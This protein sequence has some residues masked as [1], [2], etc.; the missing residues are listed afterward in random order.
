[1]PRTD[2]HAGRALLGLLLALGTLWLT[3]PGASAQ[4]FPSGP[5]G[6]AIA[7][8]PD[9][10]RKWALLIGIEKYHRANPLR[11]TINDVRCLA[12]TL[13]R[14]GDYDAESVLEIV[15]TNV[16]PR[17]QPLR[18]SLMAELPKFLARPG[19]GDHVLVYFSGH[20]FK[21]REGK[22]YLAPIDCD[23]ADPPATGISVAWF[24]EQIAACQAEVKL[25]VL[26]ACH[27]GGEKGI[28]D[29]PGVSAKELGDPF[30]DLTG[31]VTLAS[32]TSEEKS[33]I[34]EEKEQSLFSYWLDQGLRGHADRDGD[35]SVTIDELYG[36]VYRNVTGTAKLRFPKAQTPVRIVRSGTPGVPEVVRLKPQSLKQVLADVAEQLV[37]AMQER[38][39]QK[40][41]V[42]E[43]TNDT[44]LGELLGADFGLLGRYCAVE[45][46]R[47]MMDLGPG[48]F[49]V[50]D[51]RRL[52]KAL[53]DRGFGLDDLGSPDALAD[54][55]KQVGGMPAI[56]LGTLRSRAGRVVA[57]QCRLI[58]TERH[59]LAGVAGGTAVLDE[60]EWAMLGRSVQVR[61]EDRRPELPPG[62]GP[63]RPLTELVI[64]RM[65]RRSQ[66][67]HPL[68]DPSF[69][70]RVKIMVR[71]PGSKKV[72]ERPGVFRGNDLYVP[73]AQG[74]VYE[75]YAENQSG[76]LALMRLL[77]DGLNTLPDY[78][79]GS[80]D[81][82]MVVEPAAGAEDGR[83]RLPAQR[84][85]LS[86]ARAW[87]LDPER[88][89]VAA[90]RGFFSK[91]G[92]GAKYREFT[93]VD[94]RYLP[95][96]RRK[97]TDQIGLI[98][99]AFYRPK[100]DS[101]TVATVEGVERTTDVNQREGLECG[102]LIGVVH[103]RYV[104]PEALER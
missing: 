67:S 44:K 92:A 14:R 82:D 42:L 93:V 88:A 37:W 49:A 54:L 11:Y 70:F 55:S 48:K 96:G 75:I 81:K 103:I 56:A 43:F 2:T 9:A 5:A 39:L 30:R 10:P 26:D 12:D 59:E 41:G 22:L 57:L 87:I 7:G 104:E 65:D 52:Q 47:R 29:A 46:E 101:R 66:G 85:N 63:P 78:P 74:E 94:A 31:V 58:Q 99:A 3:V 25:L 100:G 98:T 27:A 32:S 62:D 68:A 51:R 95:E 13:R 15:D 24:R 23:P 21:D 80:G 33:Q 64:E 50:V 72:V 90:V 35:G 19:P 97:F 77:V 17:F 89:K 18:A 91:T 36:Y 20:G 84:V 83:E 6:G 40:V 60:S 34:W 61:P 73:L 102:N 69:P 71:R 86:E 53:A 16:N 38:R 1:M 79:M 28:D 8:Q 76:E 45:L 4:P